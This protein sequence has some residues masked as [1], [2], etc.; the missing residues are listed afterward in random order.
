MA[1]NN[2]CDTSKKIA[3]AASL[4]IS[5]SISTTSDKKTAVRITNTTESSFLIKKNTQIA[6]ISVVTLAIQVH[7]AGGHGNP[8]YDSGR[9]S[10]SDY[11]FEQINQNK[12]A[13]TTGERLLI[14]DTRKSW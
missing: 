8:Q 1:Q 2:Y 4:L 11:I 7:Q 10:G 12:P 14:P 9:L 6:E 3:E 5:H 13:T